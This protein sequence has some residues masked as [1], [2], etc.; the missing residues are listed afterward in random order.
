[1]KQDALARFCCPSC[2]YSVLSLS[3]EARDQADGEITEGVLHCASCLSAYPITGSIPRF[4]PGESDTGSFGF[5]W[6]RHRRTQLDSYTGLD[7]SRERLFAVS[8]WP[9]EMTGQQ[10]LEAGS[11]AGRFT[12]LLLASGAH[13]YSFDN[14]VAVE[15]NWENN[16][17]AANL[18]LFQ[19]D[20]F[21]IP[22][23]DASFDKVLCLGVLQH[24]PDP[25]H[26]FLSLASMVRPGGEFVM[27]V[28][29]K[30]IP[31]LL[32][33][34]YLLRPITSRMDKERLYRGAERAVD[35]MLP[36]AGWLSRKWGRAGARLLPIVEYSSLGL[37]D[38]LNR[39][40]AILDTFDMYSPAFDRPQ[41]LSTVRAWFARVDFEQIAVRRGPNGIVGKGIRPGSAAA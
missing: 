34:K 3:E 33:W 32:R 30:T 31:S 6:N 40:W 9:E 25:E 12:E 38:A 37:P 5:Q 13:V 29:A 11:G 27:D 10:I 39:E 2:H 17:A 16:R 4:V 26:A 8:G 14:S 41:S 22:F 15:A 36:L 28:Y 24:T 19:G 20:I 35:A 21:H 18:H 23:G 7:L 1:M